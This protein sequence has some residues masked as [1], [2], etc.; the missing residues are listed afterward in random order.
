[1]PAIID[2]LAWIFS[3]SAKQ[4]INP[5]SNAENMSVTPSGTTPSACTSALASMSP[6]IS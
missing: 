5:T 2:F 4:T 6:S 3:S 1:M